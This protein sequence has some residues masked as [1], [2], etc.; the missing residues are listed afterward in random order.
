MDREILLRSHFRTGDEPLSRFRFV[1]AHRDQYPVK[2]L[3]RCLAKVSRSGY[4]TW[5]SRPP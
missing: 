5:A 3:C 2:A 1:S 4:Y